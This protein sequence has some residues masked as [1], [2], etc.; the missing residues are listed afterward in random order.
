MIMKK[1]IAKFLCVVMIC[2][3]FIIPNT[4]CM[5]YDQLVEK[6]LTEAANIT[7]FIREND[8]KYGNA[9][10]NPCYNWPTLDVNN[11][12]MP[13][14]KYVACDR[15]VSWILYR[16]GFTDQPFING[17]DLE[18]LFKDHDFEKLDK[19]YDYKPGDIIFINPDSRGN[20]THVFMC[21]S[22]D[23]GGEVY[24]RYD[25][26]SDARITGTT[27]TEET[28]G[29]QPFR[30]P[31][32]NVVFAYRPSAS[33]MTTS[34]YANLYKTPSA[35]AALPG[36][37]AEKIATNKGY[38]TDVIGWGDL[39]FNENY[40]PGDDY[41]QFEFHIDFTV[42][43]SPNDD[44]WN[45][46]F[47]GARLPDPKQEPTTDGGVWLAFKQ[48]KTAYLYAGINYKTNNWNQVPLATF[49]LPEAMSEKH[50]M[51]VT[52]NGD[53]VKYFMITSTGE[54]HLICTIK[55]N[56]DLN[57]MA[58][59]DNSNKMAFVGNAVV[60]E[61]GYFRVWS[62]NAETVVENV[63]LKGYDD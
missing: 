12:I 23:L 6:M 44:P 33:N 5:T 53:M 20:P 17:C 10:V 22:E 16:A 55:L 57:W 2:T 46:A 26:G 54:Q 14:D 3:M 19:L 25:G 11:S 52:D 4:G 31:I 56:A 51:I 32:E 28:A 15:L 37:N 38:D 18:K 30:E 24:L 7:K 29:Q 39:I 36:K 40:E 49:E 47:I 61:D 1:I 35:Q 58:V 48:D 59:F 41:D 42:P 62:H 34:D 43:F 27:G 8:F 50:K 9:H 63:I 45:A 21:A 60:D 13:E